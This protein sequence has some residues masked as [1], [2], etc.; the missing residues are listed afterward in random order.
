MKEF[1]TNP[2]ALPKQV[3]LPVRRPDDFGSVNCFIDVCTTGLLSIDPQ[4]QMSSHSFADLM[5]QPYEKYCSWFYAEHV[6]NQVIAQV[7][8]RIYYKEESAWPIGPKFNTAIQRKIASGNYIHV[9]V[10]DKEWLKRVYN[11]DIS[12]RQ[13]HAVL[14][15]GYRQSAPT[16]E[17]LFE[18]QDSLSKNQPGPMGVSS[19]ILFRSVLA[20]MS[21]IH[22]NID[23]RLFRCPYGVFYWTKSATQPGTRFWHSESFPRG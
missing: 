19:T 14:I 4:L 21:L 22:P 17:L 8:T 16:G 12:T 11:V 10:D 7:E 20:S 3:S 2:E 1:P 13:T 6:V 15:T 9:G 23:G 5:P 18:V